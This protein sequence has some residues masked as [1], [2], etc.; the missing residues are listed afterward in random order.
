MK[1]SGGVDSTVYVFVGAFLFLGILVLAIRWVISPSCPE[2]VYF[3]VEALDPEID[4]KLFQNELIEF[5]TDLDGDI[6]RWEFDEE[7]TR[8]GSSVQ[9]SFREPGTYTIKLRIDDCE[10][11]QEIEILSEGERER[12][13]NIEDKPKE[14]SR[15]LAIIDAPSEVEFGTPVQ[16]NE[17]SGTA[18]SWEWVFG[19]GKFSNEQNPR[20]TY[21]TI[22][23]YTVQV[24]I[25]GSDVPVTHQISVK[26]KPEPVAEAPRR[27]TK[28]SSGGG[29][30]S[31]KAPPKVESKPEKE[32]EVTSKMFMS[33]LDKVAARKMKA[34]D[35][36]K[37]LDVEGG[38][39]ISSNITVDGEQQQLKTM[40]NTIYM[41]KEHNVGSVKITESSKGYIRGLTITT[42]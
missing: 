32:H 29:S 28:R 39:T 27:T 23:D 24:Y 35:F 40:L 25:D 9:H 4:G 7:L 26:P 22:K 18:S 2:D 34:T 36:T 16:F 13:R 33:F 20:H 12:L 37:H 11:T 42:K 21:K 15:T 41:R 5:H 14:V 19:D 38:F 1:K 6:Y 8:K 30:G 17:I 10:G 31:V 3:V